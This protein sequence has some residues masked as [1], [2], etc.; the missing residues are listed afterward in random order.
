MQHIRDALA[1]ETYETHCRVGANLFTRSCSSG[2]KAYGRCAFTTPVMARVREFWSDPRPGC[3][4]CAALEV[5]DMAEFNQ[6]QS[7]LKQLYAEQ[8]LEGETM[9]TAAAEFAAYRL[10]YALAHSA[11]QLGEELRS[12][13]QSR[14]DWLQHRFV[15]HAL[16]VAVLPLPMM[17][18]KPSTALLTTPVHAVV[19]TCI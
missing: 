18:H 11:Q 5:G 15:R 14:H 12:I 3:L 6:C 10:L 9:V 8:P 19:C 13:A 16:Q 1:I 17:R 7:M 4:R 2:S